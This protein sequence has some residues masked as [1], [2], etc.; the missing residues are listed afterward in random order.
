[1][2]EGTGKIIIGQ[3]DEGAGRLAATFHHF[4]HLII[5]PKLLLSAFNNLAG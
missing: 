1:L 2:L 5:L 3:N 4:A